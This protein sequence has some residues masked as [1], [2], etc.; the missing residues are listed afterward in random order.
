[1]KHVNIKVIGIVQGVGFRSAARSQARY[2]GIKGY[3]KNM[4][5]GSVYIEAEAEVVAMGE[6]VRWCRQGSPFARVEEVITH[7]SDPIGFST[8]EARY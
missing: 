3:V 5:D 1:M 6:F 8:F 2:L 7:E 4:P